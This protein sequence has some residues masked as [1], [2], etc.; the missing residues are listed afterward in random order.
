MLKMSTRVRYGSGAARGLGGLAIIVWHGYW[1]VFDPEY[2]PLNLTSWIGDP[3]PPG[4]EGELP[5]G[6]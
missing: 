5:Y 1:V 6:K 3:R 4:R 2:Y